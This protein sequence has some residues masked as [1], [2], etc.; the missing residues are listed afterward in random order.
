MKFK[1]RELKKLKKKQIK[2]LEKCVDVTLAS[3]N[4]NGYPRICAITNVRNNG[5]SEDVFYNIEKIAYKR[6]SYSF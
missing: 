1:K 5:F 2:L 3:I 4:E 6:K